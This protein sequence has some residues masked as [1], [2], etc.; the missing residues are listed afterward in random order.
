MTAVWNLSRTIPT[1]IWRAIS[2]LV[3]GVGINTSLQRRL[4]LDLVAYST[5]PT[6]PSFGLRL[7]HVFRCSGVHMLP[8]TY[9]P[10]ARLYRSADRRTAFLPS[11]ATLRS[12]QAP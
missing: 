12:H 1:R 2:E 7:F 10:S 3:N 11:A 5:L 6:Y 4:G 9:P 8:P